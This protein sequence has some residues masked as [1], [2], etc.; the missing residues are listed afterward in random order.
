MLQR[1]QS[2]YAIVNISLL[3]VTTYTVREA[4]IKAHLPWFNFWILLVA[5]GVM[6][7]VVAL[8]DYKW[9]FPSQMAHHQHMAYKHRNLIRRDLE[10][11]REEVKSR[12]VALDARLRR[13]E[14]ALGI[15]EERDG[16]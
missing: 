12:N 6:V 1:T 15:E 7:G 16:S 10:K 11:D 4:T 8:I 2:Y 3:L 14:K 5:L 9:V 13:I